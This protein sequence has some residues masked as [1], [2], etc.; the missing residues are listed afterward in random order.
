M[1]PSTTRFAGEGK[2]KPAQVIPFPVETARR[3]RRAVGDTVEGLGQILLYTGIRYE[4][5]SEPM[6]EAMASQR[7]HS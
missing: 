1:T 6:L 5:M 3:S 4:R 2:R 7:R